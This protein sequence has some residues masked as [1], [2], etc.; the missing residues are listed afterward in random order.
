MPSKSSSSSSLRSK[1][2]GTAVAASLDGSELAII[3]LFFSDSFDS[4]AS[5]HLNDDTGAKNFE[6]IGHT[7]M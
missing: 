1:E 6:F 5:F 4:S 3:S 2:I 7:H